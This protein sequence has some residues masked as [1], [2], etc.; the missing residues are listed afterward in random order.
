[1]NKSNLLNLKH[2]QVLYLTLPNMQTHELLA[3]MYL[4]SDKI[5]T[6]ARLSFVAVI[7]VIGVPMWWKTTEVYRVSLP[8]SEIEALT[9]TP[10]ATQAKVFIYTWDRTRSS[11]L[12]TE[13][14][15]AF[16]NNSNQSIMLHLHTYAN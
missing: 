13:L 14:S 9:D 12:A 16:S 10:I 7:L 3:N 8:Y 1:M 15:D 6:L 2:G 11:L 5:R 4:I